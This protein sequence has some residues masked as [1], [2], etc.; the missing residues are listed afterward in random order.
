MA[1]L[2]WPE[3]SAQ[4]GPLQGGPYEAWSDHIQRPDSPGK[5]CS[6][7][8]WTTG[9]EAK[10]EDSLVSSGRLSGSSGGH[11]SCAP[12]H[13]PWK[14]RAPQVLGSPRL[15]RDSNPRL[16]LLRDK[17][18]AQVQ[19]QASCASLA[20]ST[21]SSASRLCKASSPAPRRKT[22]KLKHSPPA[23]A[24]PGQRRQLPW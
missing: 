11:E 19:W 9:E 1:S 2:R 18:R 4:P 15:P 23:P 6:Y 22:R 13:R 5:A 7:P 3:P 8:V 16:E 24:S 14:E 12:P 17:I 10:D 20:T 21:P